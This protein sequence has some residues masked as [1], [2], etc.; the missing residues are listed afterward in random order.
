MASP[1]RFLPEL[2]SGLATLTS[3]HSSTWKL[4]P[5]GPKV[6]TRT[7]HHRGIRR[8]GSCCPSFGT[9]VLDRREARTQVRC[10]GLGAVARRSTPGRPFWRRAETCGSSPPSLGP[11]QRRKFVS[12]PL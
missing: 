7:E 10:A 2:P 9:A 1:R 3:H 6:D 8:F 11:E 12:V 4:A 5:V